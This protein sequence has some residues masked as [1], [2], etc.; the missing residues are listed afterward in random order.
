MTQEAGATFDH[1][2]ILVGDL[3]GAIARYEAIL[4]GRFERYVDDEELDCHWARI[5]VGGGATLELVAP[6]SDGSPYA[7]DL[8]RRGE[9]LH[10]VSFRVADVAHARHRLEGLGLGILGFTLDHAGWQE[11]FVHPRHADGVLLHLCVPPAEF[12]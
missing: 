5:P 12:A 3:D 8:E 6:R 4:G 1:I 2:G 9:G 7:R 11:L 10:H